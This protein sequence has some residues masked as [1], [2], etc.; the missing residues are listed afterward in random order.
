MTEVELIQALKTQ[1]AE[2][3][4]RCQYTSASLFIWLRWLRKIRIVFVVL[5]IVF[6]AVASWDLLKRQGGTFS[7]VTAVLAL[8]AG[9]IPA[10]YSALKLDDHL[11]TASRLAG[12][13][14][15]LEILFRDLEKIGPFKPV[16][17]FEAQYQVARERLEKANAEAYTAPEFCFRAAKKKI[18]AGH[19][20]FDQQSTT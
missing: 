7:I 12:E 14:K 1:C 4:E 8:L 17:E 16:A 3:Q 19:Y 20:S 5:P 11:P 6:G 9:V 13:Y 10:V 15:N 18:D 2:Q